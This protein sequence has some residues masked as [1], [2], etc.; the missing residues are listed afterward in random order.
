[1]KNNTLKFLIRLFIV[2]LGV[3]ISFSI[4]K[5]RALSYKEDLKNNSL[6]KMLD[7]INHDLRDKIIN[8][9]IHTN[10]WRCCDRLLDNSEELF[11]ENKDS[12]GYYIQIGS[13]ANTIF[14]DNK[15]EYLTLRNS[16]LLELIDNDSLISLLHKKYSYH[17]FYKK[18]EDGIGKLNNKFRDSMLNKISYLSIG[19]TKYWGGYG[20]YISPSPLTN[21]DLLIVK[22]KLGMSYFYSG[23]IKE[24]MKEDSVLMDMIKQELSDTE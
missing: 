14:I 6:K 5:K 2:V 15:E 22:D 20:E 3:L 8:Y 9:E 11:Q 1:M 24:S 12:L 10:A 13:M 7:N 18:I 17:P 4:E 23:I 21:S 16:G 19:K